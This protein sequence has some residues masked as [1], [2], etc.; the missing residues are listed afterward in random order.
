MDSHEPFDA[1]VARLGFTG[2]IQQIVD[3]SFADADQRTQEL[4]GNR[5]NLPEDESAIVWEDD[6][7]HTEKLR[8]VETLPRQETSWP[9]GSP[10]CLADELVTG[11]EPGN[12]PALAPSLI[13]NR[14]FRPIETMYT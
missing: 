10:S 7:D 1:S 2:A 11:I 13:A 4:F 12:S 14:V 3:D 6:L 8:Q 9:P 5:Q